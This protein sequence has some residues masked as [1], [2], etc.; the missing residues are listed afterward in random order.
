MP[1]SIASTRSREFLENVID[2]VREPLVVLDQDLRVISV[3]R[4]FYDVFHVKPKET[5][6]NLIYDL[7]NRQWDIPKLRE[8]LETILPQKTSFKD[9]EVVHSF[10]SIGQRTMLL[11]ARQIR[12][13]FGKKR[14]ILLAIEDIT[15]R[16]EIEKTLERTREDL[17]ILKI[18]EDDAREF[19]QSII[20]TIREPL[21]ALDQ[22]LRIIAV[23]RAFYEVF[24]VESDE[25][26]AKMIY[27]LGNGQWDI[28]KLRDL[29]ETLLL[30]STTFNDYEVVHD[31]STIGRRTMLLNARQIRRSLGKDKI[32]L[33]AIEDITL[34]RKME[35]DLQ[36]NQRVESLGVLAG[37]I[38]HDF[39]NLMA[40]LMANTE[41]ALA[42]LN[43]GQTDEARDRIVRTSA[44]F[45]RGRAL[46]KRLLTFSKGG[47][48]NR[49]PT[50]L[51]PLI[52][53]WV[54][55][56]LMG[57]DVT[58]SMEIDPALWVC[59]C[60]VGQIGQV[61]NN[62]LINA[63]QASHE[64]GIISIKASNL[65]KMGPYVSIEIVN[66]GKSIP[67]EIIGKI[68]DPFFTTKSE[69]SGL[70]LAIAYSIVR[71]HGGWIDVLSH[72]GQG[73]T[74][75]VFLPATKRQR[76]EPTEEKS[77]PFQG[78]GIAIVMDD[79]EDIS[80]AVG[81]MLELKGFQ[82]L[83]AN[84]GH[85]ALKKYEDVVRS[86]RRVKVLLLD[87]QVPGGMGGLATAQRLRELGSMAQIIIMSGN[88]ETAGEQSTIEADG[89]WRLPKPFTTGELDVVLRSA[90]I[91][92]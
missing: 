1:D 91:L 64:G 89:L 3:S 16:R 26:I 27:D 44:I 47:A 33:L 60:D 82:A 40:G 57:S 58:A 15:T 46:T 70:G 53:E 80:Q 31:F 12:T 9:Y 23:S 65:L 88:F 5:I 72:D 8:L 18:A 45:A 76:I 54:E 29:L 63:R 28:P 78:A 2:A 62:L 36:K 24:H 85:E 83:V 71:Q 66:G 14:I 61:I 77:E 69:G 22:D 86:G 56:A 17:A 32:I 35:E 43:S 38:A 74:F 6:G 75:T 87:N 11:N 37:G 13:T 49:T 30:Q 73:T 21:I 50:S 84:T 81:E 92:E 4:A 42:H 20:D 79:N 55:F 39:N 68:F 48:P 52:A 34:R 19:A 90:K 41:L 7:G 67:P 25:T 59:E 10:T 51:V